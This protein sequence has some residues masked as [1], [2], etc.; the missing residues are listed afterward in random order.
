MFDKATLESHKELENWTGG[1]VSRLEV[2]K[3]ELDSTSNKNNTHIQEQAKVLPQAIPLSLQRFLISCSGDVVPPAS[4]FSGNASTV[5]SNDNAE[6][7]DGKVE[8]MDARLAFETLRA[9][10]WRRELST[11]IIIFH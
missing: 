2:G 8:E 3:K 11:E 7:L 4:M 10:L 1:L 6:G 5:L 9:L